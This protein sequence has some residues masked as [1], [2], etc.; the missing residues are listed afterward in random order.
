MQVIQFYFKHLHLVKTLTYICIKTGTYR[1]NNLKGRVWPDFEADPSFMAP[2]QDTVRQESHLPTTTALFCLYS[3]SCQNPISRL[4]STTK[5][6]LKGL[7]FITWHPIVIAAYMSVIQS[8]KWHFSIF[9]KKEYFF[10]LEFFY[11]VCSTRAVH[12][13]SRWGSF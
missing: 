3:S 13:I 6:L 4:F 5:P 1:G 7:T 9:N 10:V 11:P 12:Q 8:I 2:I